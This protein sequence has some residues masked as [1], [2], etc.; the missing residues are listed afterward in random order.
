MSSE[1]RAFLERFKAWKHRK[2][3]FGPGSDTDPTPQQVFHDLMKETFAPALRSVGLKG[4]GGRFE[5]PSERYWAQLGFQKSAYS[6]SAVLMFTVNLSVINREVWAEQ[7]SA[8][9]HLG[10]EA[11]AEAPSTA[12]GLSRFA[13]GD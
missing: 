12:H 8:A 3:D 11:K 13:L 7:A 6:D 4:S 10:E 1:E 5:L 2:K 9:P